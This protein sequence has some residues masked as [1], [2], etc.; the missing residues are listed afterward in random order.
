MTVNNFLADGGEQRTLLVDHLDKHLLVNGIGHRGVRR[1]TRNT[2]LAVL[3]VLRLLGELSLKFVK[4]PL[5]HHNI[6][7]VRGIA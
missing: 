2:T 5:R 7:V 4:L 6:G 3:P 1:H